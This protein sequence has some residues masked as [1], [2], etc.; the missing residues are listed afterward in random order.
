[1]TPPWLKPVTGGVE[2]A[3][4]VKPKAT[5]SCVA[6]T[7]PGAQGSVWL[8]VRVTEPADGGRATAAVLRLIAAECG[9]PAR[10]VSLVSGS[11][12]RFKRLRVAGAVD[13]LGARFEA[14]SSR[15][16]I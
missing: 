2:L 12:S 10:D 6:G 8:D 5:S 14:L 13:A 15:G 11:T 7:V 16:E 4:K 3:V 1:M 9:V